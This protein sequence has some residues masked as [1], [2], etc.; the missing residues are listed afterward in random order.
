MKQ[1]IESFNIYKNI[2]VWI[3]PSDKYHVDCVYD[4]KAKNRS[5]EIN[6][7]IEEINSRVDILSNSKNFE[8]FKMN[9]RDWRINKLVD[10]LQQE[11]TRSVE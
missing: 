3:L 7:V 9:I 11:Q 2:T 8:D 10:E 1:A 4:G 6:H 5:E